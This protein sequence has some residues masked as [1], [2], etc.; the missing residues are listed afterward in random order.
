MR[1]DELMGSLQ[2][3]EMNLNQGRREKDIALKIEATSPKELQQT[4]DIEE[5]GEIALLIK[6]LC[7]YFRKIQEEDKAYDADHITTLS[8]PTDG[9]FEISGNKGFLMNY[10]ECP[11]GHV[12]FGD[13]QKGQVVGKGT[14]M[15]RCVVY[16]EA[17]H[18]VL[19]G[20]R[21]SNN[22]YLL[23]KLE[24]C[25]NT[26]CNITEIWH[27][28]LGHLNFRNLM[29]ITEMKVVKGVPKLTKREGEIETF[30]AFKKLCMQLQNEK[31][32]QIGKIVK[33]RS[34]HGREF[35]NTQFAEFSEETWD[36]GYEFSTPKTPQQNG[37]V[38]RKN[39]TPEMISWE[40]LTR[41]VMKD[42]S[43]DMETQGTSSEPNKL[44]TVISESPDEELH[45][46]QDVATPVITP[47]A[48]MHNAQ[49]FRCDNGL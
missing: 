40:S 4:E 21:S 49:C 23:E 31:E 47:T 42:Y 32:C 17:G 25:Y 12:T 10:K 33:I 34:D 26:S 18:C 22:C 36:S 27:H 43:W 19:T 28:K 1:L 20:S 9:D 5:E 35:E 6:E 11:I 8:L 48:T 45:E 46:E 30:E 24:V 2:A 44:I 38:E 15:D 3:H 16:D 37:V 39:R 29:K 13:G 7:R 41:K 14:L